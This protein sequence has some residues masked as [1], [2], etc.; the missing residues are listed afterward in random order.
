M[1]T[2]NNDPR[3]AIS[4]ELFWRVLLVGNLMSLGVVLL[5]FH[6]LTEVAMAP[7]YGGWII[8]TGLLMVLPALL[9]RQHAL[10]R[11]ERM[12]REGLSENVRQ[13]TRLNQ[14]VVGC[15]LAELPGLLGGGYYLFSREWGGTVVLLLAT[16]ILLWLV[17][18]R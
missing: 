2:E 15:A 4:P 9:Y 14:L 11:Q 10:R 7:M 18:P 3:P 16:V 8:A 17:K 13:L 5:V 6:Q 12:V 1:M